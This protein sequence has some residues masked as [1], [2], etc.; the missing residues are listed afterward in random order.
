M[1]PHLYPN[2]SDSG[3]LRC[4]YLNEVSFSRAAPTR[5]PMEYTSYPA[6]MNLVGA[7]VSGQVAARP[8]PEGE[9]SRVCVGF[10]GGGEGVGANVVDRSGGNGVQQQGSKGIRQG[11]TIYSSRE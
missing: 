10:W 11:A 1:L 8:M 6:D 7:R 9:N 5:C 4:M 3:P 2:D